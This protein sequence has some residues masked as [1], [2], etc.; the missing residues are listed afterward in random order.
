ML[1]CPGAQMV[2]SWNGEGLLFFKILYVL[3]VIVG[4]VTFL[5]VLLAMLGIVL[6]VAPFC[7][8]F[9]FV[10][11]SYRCECWNVDSEP[12]KI[13]SQI[14][15]CVL[16]PIVLSFT[17]AWV[18]MVLA[19]FVVSLPFQIYKAC[20]GAFSWENALQLAVLPVFVLGEIVDDYDWD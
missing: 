20:I 15:G 17:I 1:G 19:W 18:C 16:A 8:L 4:C 11:D 7:C 3:L 9:Q 12:R 2:S 14:T 6:I 13:A 5:G 10:P